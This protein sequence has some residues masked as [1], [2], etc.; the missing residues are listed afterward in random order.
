M[1]YVDFGIKDLQR[2]LS[3]MSE[4][5]GQKKMSEEDVKLRNKLEVVLE[6]EKEADNAEL[7]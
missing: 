6:A 7:F 4:F 5:F 1:S 2:I 3:I